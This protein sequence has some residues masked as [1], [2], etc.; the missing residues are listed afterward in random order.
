MYCLCARPALM[1]AG[2]VSLNQACGAFAVEKYVCHYYLT[3][4]HYQQCPEQFLLP[5]D[6][7]LIST[8]ALLMIDDDCTDIVGHLLTKCLYLEPIVMQRFPKQ[9]KSSIWGSLPEA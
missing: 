7:S 2:C 1:L 9:S 3:H 6:W 5:Y 8:I 4:C